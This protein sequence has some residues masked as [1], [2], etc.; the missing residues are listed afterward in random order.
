MDFDVAGHRSNRVETWDGT[1]WN[2]VTREARQLRGAMI[3]KWRVSDPETGSAYE[4]V[5]GENDSTADYFGQGDAWIL[6]YH[7]GELDDSALTGAAQTALSSFVN[8]ESVDNQ[9]IVFWYGAH[10]R[11]SF[12]QDPRRD[13]GHIVGPTIRP[14]NW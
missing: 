1:Q 4:I 10:F 12:D 11:H 14:L 5:P 13:V 2:L 7:P 8:G 3:Q 9:D 6:A